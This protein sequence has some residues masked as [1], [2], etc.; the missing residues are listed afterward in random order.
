MTKKR[1]RIYAGNNYNIKY[2]R[3]FYQGFIQIVVDKTNLEHN[4][5]LMYVAH[6][7]LMWHAFRILAFIWKFILQFIVP[8]FGYTHDLR[9]YGEW[10]VVTGCT[11]GI[12]LQYA[13][14]L[15][16]KG[17]NIVL[18][19]RSEEKLQ[20]VSREVT[21]K[22]NVKTKVIV[23][24]FGKVDGYKNIAK[25]LEDLDIGILVN[26]VGTTYEKQTPSAVG[27]IYGEPIFS[28][29]DLQKIF[30]VITI[31]T[32]SCVGM[33]HAVIQGMCKRKRGLMIHVSSVASQIDYSFMV[34]YKATKIFMNKFVKCLSYENEGI[35]DHQL[36]VP[37][38][39]E[40]KL[41]NMKAT[42]FVCPT[43]EDYVKSAIR[44]IGFADFTS[45]YWSH[46][47][48]EILFQLLIHCL[49]LVRT[50]KIYIK[51]SNVMQNSNTD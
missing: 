25:E 49:C 26:N 32:F 24:D 23:Y 50:V 7:I 42:F 40:T 3:Y 39:V 16:A 30:D 29:C 14:Q 36:L 43:A 41:S 28:E 15:A 10:A 2:L 11:D 45:G 20:T 9:K 19:S 5:A 17:F 35:I 13:L 34:V 46:K 27:T 8:L 6:I 18:I 48:S 4:M 38:L 33:S 12:G 47:L 1:S 21:E 44:T 31:N 51:K 37:G 22:F